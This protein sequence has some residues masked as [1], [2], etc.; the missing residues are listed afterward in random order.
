[1]KPG[2]DPTF[3]AVHAKVAR[4][5]YARWLIQ[6]RLTDPDQFCRFHDLAYRFDQAA[7]TREKPVFVKHV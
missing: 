4:G 5:A 7:S 3:V 1:M 6:T 2:D